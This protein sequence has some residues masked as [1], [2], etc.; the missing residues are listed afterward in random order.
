MLNIL[1]IIP[2]VVIQY[3]LPQDSSGESTK[4]IKILTV[5][6]SG[7]LALIGIF[8]A[9]MFLP[10][11]FPEFSESLALIP[12]ISIAIIPI[13]VSSMYISKFLGNEQSRFI[14]ISYLLVIAVL[15]PGIIIFGDK[16]GIVGLAI[17]F[18]SAESA[19][20]IFL[21]IVNHFIEKNNS[22]SKN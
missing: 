16:M 5:G 10:I 17:I 14:V 7:L 19:K 21:T 20:A 2:E 6:V 18:V 15:V 1:S 22:L 11:F 4:K 3:T 9:P 13:T 8:I 12:I